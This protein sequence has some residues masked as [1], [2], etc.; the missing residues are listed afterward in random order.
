M[1][2]T[3]HKTANSIRKNRPIVST[4][5]R[6][7]HAVNDILLLPYRVDNAIVNKP[8]KK[9]GP[10]GQVTEKSLDKLKREEIL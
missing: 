5:S 1:S 4:Q 2:S 3:E 6:F 8:L 10:G 9:N 7:P